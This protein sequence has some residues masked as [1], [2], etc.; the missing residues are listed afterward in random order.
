MSETKKKGKRKW[1]VIAVVVIVLA[2]AFL[3]LRSCA[4]SISS[5]MSSSD[6][7]TTEASL[8]SIATTV[9]GSGTLTSQDA[10]S[11]TVPE[12]VEID[13]TYVE[14]GDQVSQGDILA[15]VDTA[16]V[17]SAMADT[18]ADIDELD[19]QLEEIK[20]DTIS[21]S[22]TAGISGR[23]KKIL[24]EE[25][26]SV[27]AA[28]QDQGALMLLSLDGKMA[29]FLEGVS[30]DLGQT[31]TVTASD[32][33]TYEGTVAEATSA[34]I[35]VTLTDKG[36]AYGDAVTITDEGE[37]QLG[38]GTL[39][40]HSELRVTGYTG[41]VDS[42]S[43]SEGDW[44]DAGD[45][46]L[47]LTE[48]GHTAEYETLLS[49]REELADQLKT[50][51]ALYQ[52][53][54]ITAPFDGT[55][56]SIDGETASTTA[57]SDD[58]GTSSSS[59]TDIS[60]IFAAY[61]TMSYDGAAEQTGG[62]VLLGAETTE[63]GETGDSSADG[64]EADTGT[65][66]ADGT[67]TGTDQGTGTNTNTD[68]D[69]NTDADANT[70][71]GGTVTAVT[72]VT[73]DISAGVLLQ[74]GS[75]ADYE[76]QF[77][78]VLM[79]G[80]NILQEKTNSVIG[81]ITFDTLT[82]TQAGTHTY[83][84]GQ[85]AGT[86][87]A[88]TYD[89]TVYTLVVTVTTAE[90]GALSIQAEV[91]DQD[92]DAL[93]FT[94]VLATD[95]SVSTDISDILSDVDLDSY[96]SSITD[97]ITGTITDSITSSVSGSLTSGLTSS[98]SLGDTSSLTT[99]TSTSSTASASDTTVMTIA[100][101]EVMS[102]SISVDELDILSLEKGQEAAVTIDAIEGE[103]FTG[104]VTAIDTI[105][106]SSG[107]VAKFTVQVAIEKTAQMLSG[108]NASVEITIAESD[109]CLVIPE[110]ALNQ[111]GNTTYVYTS[112]DESSDTLGG[113]TEVT[114]GVSDGT[115]VEILTGLSEGDTVYYRY[116]ESTSI[117][118]LYASIL[119]VED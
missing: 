8:G 69:S 88:I 6:I 22:V 3:G 50:L 31:V 96:T 46:L 82:Y 103:T 72:P 37:N 43:V 106:S 67:E 59:G 17:L 2:A 9:S 102:V 61:M 12:G 39:Y 20:D 109:D 23:V 7:R 86:D 56:Q 93:I 44:A 99:S 92:S 75:I 10:E 21:E 13:T 48:L 68:T 24:V 80:E 116:A 40:I 33:E 114:T 84:L 81:L 115:S 55:I 57:V 41:T 66:D 58:S 42:I 83:Q 111:S 36:P 4:Q 64:T 27:A 85:I 1:I 97:S 45:T 105:G 112:Y 29:V 28:M 62:I 16:T 95:S 11:I 89:G 35:T 60:S 53:N 32:G 110:D 87:S 90:N 18:Q 74:G 119:G 15:T 71:S 49:Q 34:G 78:F 113:E 98:Y 118:D 108:M 51:T 65:Q 73:L 5:Q 79:E 30:A 25:G 101:N 54:V 77:T 107:G 117:L 14:V 26:D 47:K 63:E 91:A 94:N 76:G 52:D 100:P 70:G 104:V 19:A 38:T